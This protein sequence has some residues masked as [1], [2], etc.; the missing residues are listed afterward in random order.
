MASHRHLLRLLDDPFFP[1]P[2]PPPSSSCPFLPPSSPFAFPHHDLDIFLPSDPFFAPFP[3]PTPHAYLL[4]DLTDRV[5]ALELA[6]APHPPKPATSRRK[7]TYATQ[8]PGGR[9]AK[10]TAE[11]NPRSGE[12]ALKWE[13][14][15][16]C[17]NPDGFDRKW[18]WEAKSKPG[19]SSAKTKWAAEIKGKGALEPW[20]H[21]YTWEEEEDLSSSDD[22]EEL[23]Y[24]HRK[25][26]IKDKKKNKDKAAKE[27]K[28]EKK[29]KVGGNVNVRIE[30][31]P[32]DNT[33][34]C[35]AI[36]KAFAMGNGKGKA[37]ELSP[38]DAALLIQMNYRAHLA[39]RSQVLRCLR[40]LAVAKAK[41][42]ELRSMFYNLSYRRRISHDHEERQRFSE[43]IIVL[44]LT[45]DALEGP[46]YM[47]RTAKKSMLE[48]LEGMLDIV[49]PQPVGKQRS[50]SRRKFD[51]PEG[52]G[53]IP[54]EKTASVNNAVRVINTGKK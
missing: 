15:L 18:K 25:P 52:G 37:K 5:A 27:D 30:E 51:L 24:R 19:A 21:A 9:K 44:L 32:E 22:D 13:A 49:D 43:K 50:F 46:D 29:N 41:L 54:A 34:G 23:Y 36:R 33:A 31:I 14:E 4:H 2:S 8:T 28:K 20:S 38:Q 45:V 7:Y 35:V 47:V 1:F 17:P 16:A 6:L 42:K 12:R 26:E 40:D 10:W 3:T 11:D 53:A 39:H 48:E